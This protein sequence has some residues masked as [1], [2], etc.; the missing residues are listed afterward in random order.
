MEKFKE[1]WLLVEIYNHILIDLTKNFKDNKN[2]YIMLNIK[3]NLWKEKLLELRE[4][5]LLKKLKN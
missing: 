4:S 5:E 2:Y 3:F 1:P